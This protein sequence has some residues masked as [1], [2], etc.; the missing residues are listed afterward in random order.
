[1]D[2]REGVEWRGVGRKKRGD[3]QS[4]SVWHALVVCYVF[5][6][7]VIKVTNRLYKQTNSDKQDSCDGVHDIKLHF[8]RFQSMKKLSELRAKIFTQATHKTAL[9]LRRPIS[10]TFLARERAVLKVKNHSSTPKEDGSNSLVSAF[11]T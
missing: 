2:R 6:L 4:F 10:F 3:E 5:H 11:Y 8:A 1:V 7:I 9:F